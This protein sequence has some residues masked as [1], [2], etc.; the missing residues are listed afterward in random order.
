MEHLVQVQLVQWLVQAV[1][2]RRNEAIVKPNGITH[3][4]ATSIGSSKGVV[5]GTKIC[6]TAKVV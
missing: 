4:A 1:A 5:I 2:A 3:M 6:V